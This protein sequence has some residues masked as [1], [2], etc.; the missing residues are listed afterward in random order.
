MPLSVTS[1]FLCMILQMIYTHP[2]TP[3]AIFLISG[4]LI[5]N[6]HRFSLSCNEKLPITI[7]LYVHV[8]YITY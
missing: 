8:L 7:L 2:R 4:S 1:R 3:Q 6:C 5:D